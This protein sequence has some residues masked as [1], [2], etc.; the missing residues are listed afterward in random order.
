MSTNY[1]ETILVTGASG[2][3]G[4]LVLTHLMTTLGISPTQII[5][6]S[7]NPENLSDWA[8]KGV[9]TRKA[10][11]NDPENL[12]EAFKGAKRLLLVSTD[13]LEGNVR[14]GQ[15]LRAVEA[16][17]AAGV[18]HI[19]YTSLPEAEDSLIS[20]APDHLGTENAIKAL[21]LKWTFLRNGWYF[22]NLLFTIPAALASGALYTAAGDGKLAYISRSDLALAAA[23]ALV[24]TSGVEN[25]TLTLTGS[26]VLTV[27]EVAH[28]ISEKVQKPISVVQ[29]PP[30][31]IIEGAKSHGVPEFVAV[32]FASFDMATKAGQLGAVTP[33]FAKLTGKSPQPFSE[34]LDDNVGLFA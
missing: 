23:S 13:S 16:A 14:L 10:D 21:G 25:Q 9:Q 27:E 33:D 4:G 29:V 22:E 17:K 2:K 31:A 30:E 19:L 32:M 12:I 24:A 3:F 8:A 18:E 34:W 11:Y 15:H 26:E 28:L 1:T 20:F 6:T 7:R 5:A